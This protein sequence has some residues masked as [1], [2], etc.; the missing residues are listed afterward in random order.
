[1]KEEWKRITEYPDYEISNHGNLRD[2]KTKKIKPNKFNNPNSNY[3]YCIFVTN[4]I[5]NYVNIPKTVA[6]EFLGFEPVTQL[7][8]ITFIDGNPRN[9]HVSNLRI[10]KSID[11]NGRTK[12]KVNI[13][14]YAFPGI[15]SIS[16]NPI[17]NTIAMYFGVKTK[18]LKNKTRRREVVNV[19]RYSSYFLYN[20]Y[21]VEAIGEM[22]N[23]DYSTVIYHNKFVKEML[24]FGDK[25]TTKIVNELNQILNN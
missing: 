16:S 13:S 8:R 24:D 2:I 20:R 19:K 15:P 9:C 6:K 12:K 21:I 3:L 18:L 25:E 22:L 14:P 17:I 23:I 10:E 1:M 5:R 7:D 4:Y 11:V